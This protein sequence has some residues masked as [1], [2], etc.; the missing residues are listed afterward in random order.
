MD[1]IIN[2]YVFAFSSGWVSFLIGITITIV[3]AIC[4]DYTELDILG[5]WIVGISLWLLSPLFYLLI[6]LL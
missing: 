5:K 4:M 1:A 3:I 6:K 2:V